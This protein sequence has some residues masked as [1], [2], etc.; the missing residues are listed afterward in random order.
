MGRGVSSDGRDK[1]FCTKAITIIKKDFDHR[2]RCYSKD[3]PDLSS[4]H[5]D[6]DINYDIC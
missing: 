1:P 2:K 3:P 5:S 6:F 4:K